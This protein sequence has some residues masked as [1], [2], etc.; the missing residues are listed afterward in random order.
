MSPLF[1]DSRKM[2]LE[3]GKSLFDYADQAHV[4]IPTSCGRNGECHECIV[5][6]RR[7]TDIL[8]EPSASEAFLK[9]GF[10]LAC[11]AK[12]RDM[13]G[14]IEFMVTRRQPQIL[15]HSIRRDIDINPLTI[16]HGEQVRF[17]GRRIDE[18]RRNI[19]G[20]AIDIGTTTVAMLSLIHI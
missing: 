10:R 20:L 14:D 12:I 2:D 3:L 8:T 13:E 18:Y 19:F 5:E 17:N 1:H 7:N 15:T 6:V 16:R 11:Q 4:R 9:D